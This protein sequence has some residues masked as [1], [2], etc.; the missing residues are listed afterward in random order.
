MGVAVK[1]RQVEETEMT[2]LMARQATSVEKNDKPLPEYSG[3]GIRLSR[4]FG[5][6]KLMRK[7][8][9]RL[10]SDDVCNAAF[11]GPAKK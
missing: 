5:A 6:E 1:S 4:Q 3:R 11:L 10:T 2:Y 7:S 9:Y 8:K